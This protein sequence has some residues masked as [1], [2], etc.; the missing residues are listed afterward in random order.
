M[1]FT[2]TWCGLWYRYRGKVLVEPRKYSDHNPHFCLTK[3]KT[4]D[5][6][7]YDSEPMSAFIE[8]LYSVVDN[9]IDT[10]NDSTMSD[11]DEEDVIL[12]YKRDEQ[13][14]YRIEN[15]KDYLSIDNGNIVLCHINKLISDSEGQF[16]PDYDKIG[17]FAHTLIAKEIP[18]AII[19]TADELSKE[20]YYSEYTICLHHRTSKGFSYYQCELYDEGIIY[21]IKERHGSITVYHNI[22]PF[23]HSTIPYQVLDF[24]YPDTNIYTHIRHMGIHKGENVYYPCH[25]DTMLADGYIKTVNVLIGFDEEKGKCRYITGEIA[26]RLYCKLDR[27]EK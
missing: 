5:A 7:M 20:H 12:I 2:P 27:I 8:E 13:F 10:I 24:L 11:F 26:N 17:K 4:K 1:R 3:S 14:L 21:I 23:A 15:F 16:S 22:E 25:E 18:L 9:F 6:T 19:E